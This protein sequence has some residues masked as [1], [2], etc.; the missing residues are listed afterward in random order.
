MAVL[1]NSDR[2]I[3]KGDSWIDSELGFCQTCE[4]KRQLGKRFE[5]IVKR[6]V[7]VMVRLLN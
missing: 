2:G 1:S 3:E 7:K 4:R 6:E 5:E